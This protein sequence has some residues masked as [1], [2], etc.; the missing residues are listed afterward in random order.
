[1][2]NVQN[3][4]R[5]KRPDEWAAERFFNFSS[6]EFSAKMLK[7]TRETI[8]AP[9]TEIKASDPEASKRLKKKACTCFSMIQKYMGDRKDK[10][11]VGT[12]REVVAEGLSTPLLRD[13]IYLQIIK[14]L[15]EN[16]S[17]DS[18]AKGWKI[19]ALCLTT[20]PPGADFENFLEVYLRKYATPAPKYVGALHKISFEGAMRTPPTLE[21]MV[22]VE[23]TLATRSR[24]FSEP[25]PPA[26]PSYQDLLDKYYAQEEIHNE[27]QRKAPKP[28][29]KAGG[30]AAGGGGGPA[31]RAGGAGA[32]GARPAKAAPAAEE[33]PE[34]KVESK[35]PAKRGGAPAAAPPS[36]KETPCAWKEAADP[37]SGAIYYYNEETGESSWDRPPALN[38][39]VRRMSAVSRGW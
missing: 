9:L 14:Q 18:I 4:S 37:T 28:A 17:P 32:G 25:L 31:K 19:M 16:P 8:H 35:A 26:Q 20:F 29:K 33:E 7:H 11:D 13:E 3:Y 30:A 39:A 10:D 5:L 27:F 6:E 22:Q 1:M 23:E 34:A 12:G 38:P 2:F 36:P 15:T 24:G 21:Q